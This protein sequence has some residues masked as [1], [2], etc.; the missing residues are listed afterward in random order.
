[1]TQRP[2]DLIVVPAVMQQRLRL[3][4]FDTQSMLRR[5][6][7]PADL[8][9]SGKARITTR[10]MFAVWDALAA[11]NP[12]PA[13]GLRIGAEGATEHY[14]IAS[15]AALHSPNFGEALQ[16]L[17]RFKRL[18]CPEVI[19]IERGDGE[20]RV[21]FHWFLAEG[22]SPPLL[23]DGTFASVLEL[24]RRGTGTRVVPRRVELVRAHTST[25]AAMLGAHFG[26]AP[27]FGATA[28]VIVF[29][30]ALLAQPFVT[31]NQDLLA[32]LLPGLE[33]AL[34]A[35][36]PATSLVDQ[37][38]AVLGRTLRGERPS[39]QAVAA[40]L[41]VS[42][43][44]LQRRLEE[45]GTSYQRLLDE[46]RHQAARQL[47]EDTQLEAGEIAFVLG[48]EELNSFTRAFRGW[49]GTT[50]ARWRTAQAVP[51]RP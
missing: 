3:L 31:H 48:F 13:L 34:A 7:L 17:S 21:R 16:R 46:V 36:V 49:E 22:H 8:F 35:Q 10:Q 29:D 38:R 25:Q 24:A 15:I 1:M 18:T 39:I 11:M 51:E 5:A 23:T 40:E 26:C 50:P 30:E 45:A 42:T 12:D 2:P 33:A 44:T 14:D 6:G 28:D 27:R 43:R 47:L 32:V 9:A 19:R 37:A 41:C 20:V 4:G